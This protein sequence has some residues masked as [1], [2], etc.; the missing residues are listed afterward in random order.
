MYIWKKFL[1]KRS[2]ENYTNFW[3]N[4]TLNKIECSSKKMLN[5]ILPAKEVRSRALTIL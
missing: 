3:F 4:F 2:I 5:V 1:V